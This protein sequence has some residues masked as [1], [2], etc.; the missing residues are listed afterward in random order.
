MTYHYHVV[1]CPH[2]GE[3]SGGVWCNLDNC[4]AAAVSLEPFVSSDGYKAVRMECNKT[5]E[6]YY[7]D[8]GDRPMKEIK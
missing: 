6:I 8:F 1:D 5:D 4:T 3:S 7:V 2:C